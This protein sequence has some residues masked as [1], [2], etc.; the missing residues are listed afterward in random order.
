MKTRSFDQTF[1][2]VWPPAGPPEAKFLLAVVLFGWFSI[3]LSAGIITVEPNGVITPGSTLTINILLP[4]GLQ[5]VDME[6]ARLES[7][8]EGG[9]DERIIV[10]KTPVADG[11]SKGPFVDGNPGKGI[12]E[13]A[14]RLTPE[15]SSGSYIFRVFRGKGSLPDSV[16]IEITNRP[17]LFPIGIKD[18]LAVSRYFKGGTDRDRTPVYG[19]LFLMN[20]KTYETIARLTETGDCLQPTWSPDGKRIAYVRWFNGAGQL[21][22]LDVEKDKP[23]ALPRRLM[24]DFPGSVM[25]PLWSPDGKDIAFLSGESLWVMKVGLLNLT[26]ALEYC[27][28][29][30]L[31]E[32]KYEP[33]R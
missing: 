4:A 30:N 22:V 29:E 17:D 15:F 8:G 25:N 7:G 5:A 28:L 32:D 16:M 18:T 1:S 14:L 23:A 19:D 11:N 10:K 24:K 6:I 13:I 31:M 2:K 9:T 12:I 3:V 27:I 20:G 21:W 26:K 33:G